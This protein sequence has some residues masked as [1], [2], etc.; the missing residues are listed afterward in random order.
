MNDKITLRRAVSPRD[1]AQFWDEMDA[2]LLRDVVPNCDLDEP[3]PSE[4]V[5]YFRSTAYREGIEAICRRETNPGSRF[6]FELDGQEVGFVLSVLYDQEDGKCFLIDFCIYPTYRCQGVGKACFAAL[7]ERMAA[8]GAE[9]FELNTHCRRSKRFWESLGFRYNGYDEHG[10]I[11][12]CRP[13][14][15]YLPFTA[16]RLTEPE[17]PELGW[18]VRKLMNGFLSEIGE[19]RLDDEA[20]ERLCMAVRD[21]RLTF[22]LA[23]RGCRAV[24]MC[25]VSRCFSTFT[26]RDIGLLDDF[27][28]EPVFRSQGG[29]R[30]LT[31]TA[32]I[33]CR[34]QEMA[35]LTLG[36]SAGDVEMYQ[37]L[38]FQE[39]LGAMLACLF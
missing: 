6:F 9:Y 21:E 4:D 20:W 3:L 24:G 14:E 17:D 7:A 28:I 5:E 34:E 36:C 30:L 12:L 26:C 33:W 18:Q 39:D 38:G 1:I 13:P 32:Q 35:S 11:L 2:M 31:Q 25:S 16:V 29:A 10:T 19:K 8:E 22:F 15:E 23:R 27:F 37:A